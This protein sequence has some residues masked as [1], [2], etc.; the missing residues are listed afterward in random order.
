MK[1]PDLTYNEYFPFYTQKSYGT[2]KY[3][4]RVT[5]VIHLSEKKG[6]LIEITYSSKKISKIELKRL[7]GYPDLIERKKGYEF[8]SYPQLA[9]ELKILINH[10]HRSL[11]VLNSTSAY[12]ENTC[13]F[14]SWK[15]WNK[16]VKLKF[17]KSENIEI[18]YGDFDEIIVDGKRF[19]Q[20]DQE[21]YNDIKDGEFSPL[22]ALSK[23]LDE[24]T[25]YK[26]IENRDFIKELEFTTRWMF[27]YFE[28]PK[29]IR[30]KE[31]KL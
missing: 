23:A 2:W 7:Y 5:S 4:K 31:Y 19:S 11:R 27:P 22:R 28:A 17:C 24:N 16:S 3:T 9:N 15:K 8:I 12:I 13:G 21:F 1:T 20:K 29:F 30:K 26:E 25:S 6:Y 10:L 14:Y 18:E